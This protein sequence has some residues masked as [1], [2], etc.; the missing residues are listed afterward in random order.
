MLR[1]MS[2]DSCVSNQAKVSSLNTGFHSLG[3]SSMIKLTG[4]PRRLCDGVSRR[5]FLQIG[6]LGAFG[7]SAALAGWMLDV[8]RH[9]DDESLASRI[10]GEV[11]ELC[12]HFAVP[13]G[14]L[15]GATAN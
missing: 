9:P 12:K 5:D 4:S 1:E 2:R 13:A 3:H 14:R 7:L 10:R 15:T 8:L 11:R 6:G